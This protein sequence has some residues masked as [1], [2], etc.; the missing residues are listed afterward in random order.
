MST[1]RPGGVLWDTMSRVP[2]RDLVGTACLMVLHQSQ[3]ASDGKTGWLPLGPGDVDAADEL[4]QIVRDLVGYVPTD[5]E[6]L[7]EKLEK[8][9]ATT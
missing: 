1:D 9:E 3:P 7:R 6:K 2:V 4:L 8:L 5:E